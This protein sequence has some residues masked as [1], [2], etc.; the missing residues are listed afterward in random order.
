MRWYRRELEKTVQKE[1]ARRPAVLVTG[2]RQA[3]KTSLLQRALP[4]Y[5]YV[6]LDLPRI[7]EEAESAGEAFLTRH[8]P[9]I[10]LDEVQHAPGLFPYLKAA[11]DGQ[12][13]RVGQFILSG[14]QKFGL[15]AGVTESLAGRISILECH[16]LAAAEYGLPV[17]PQT[18]VE[19]IWRGGYPEIH[20]RGLDVARFYADYVVTYLQRDVRQVIEVRNLRNFDRF[21]RLAA[22]R[23]GQ[24]ANAQ[25]LAADLGIS[26]NT[27]RAW[28]SVLETSNVLFML[29]DSTGF[30]VS[31]ISSRH[32]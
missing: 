15:M 14:S 30:C 7:A 28:L 11:I 26:P 21:L 18:I 22:A 23:T 16:S 17:S 13:H 29:P 6:S 32:C 31:G 3:G 10:I 2:S 4:D 20:A 19:W 8:G 9:P 24:L 27:V 5:T 12:R 25:T 1:A